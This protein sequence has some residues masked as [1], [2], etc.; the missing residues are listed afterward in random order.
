MTTSWSLFAHG[1]WRDAVAT[2]V[3]GTALAVVALVVGMGAGIV[4]VVG[5]PLAWQPSH[6]LAAL[7]S[8]VLAAAVLCEWFWR[9]AGG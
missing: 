1:R 6:N 2:H 5:K 8:L 3:T 9:L 4:A 7:A